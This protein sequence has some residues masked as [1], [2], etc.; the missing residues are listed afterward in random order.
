MS[1]LLT[2]QRLI[3]LGPII[4]LVLLCGV[5]GTYFYWYSYGA[6]IKSMQ[7]LSRVSAQ[8]LLNLMKP[9]V[10][11]GNYANI[12]DKDAYKLYTSTPDL[13]FFSVDG[14]TDKAQT[15]YGAIYL[16]SKEKLWRTA[17]DEDYEKKLLEKRNK[18]EAG[19]EKYASNPKR[20]E[21]LKPMLAKIEAEISSYEEARMVQDNIKKS[22]TRPTPDMLKEGFYLDGKN[23]LLHLVLPTGNPGGGEI[24]MVL[25]ATILSNTLFDVALKSAL[26]SIICLIAASMTSLFFS[27]QITTLIKRITSNMQELTQGNYNIDI[28]GSERIDEIGEMARALQIFQQTSVEKE[29]MEQKQ[30]KEQ[31]EK[32]RIAIRTEEL[33]SEFD[34]NIRIFLHDLLNAMKSLQGTSVTLRNVADEGEILSDSL[35]NS[36]E[37]A[38]QNVSTVSSTAEELSSSIQEITSQIVHSSKIS[39]K[40]VEKSNYATQTIH[41]LQGSSEKIGEVVDLIQAIAE[42]TNLLALNATIEAARAGDAG[43]G[44]AVV[45]NEVKSL[46]SQTAKATE[47]I[48]AQ[49]TSTQKSTKETVTA[50]SAVSETIQEMNEITT[51]MSA[52]MEEQAAAMSEIVRSANGAYDSTKEVSEVS[53]KVAGASSKTKDE[54]NKL[55]VAADDLL[56]KTE[57]LRGEVEVFLANIKTV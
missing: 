42:Q 13:I 53:V 27:K 45:A 5:L 51:S 31:N 18:I 48:A 6:T 47:E 20:Q 24:W 49:V 25:D 32:E 46:A 29:R 3:I 16:S 43:K 10:G 55:G 40:A 22:Y 54:A 21:K 41:N 12:Q 15:H 35:S 7:D 56:N 37:T 17:Y 33:T 28:E 30:L 19:I 39:K 26:I 50:I 11:G 1:H 57:S 23:K 36:S 38:S 2:L 34:E 9:S 8:P 4:L 44:F 52:A 14:K